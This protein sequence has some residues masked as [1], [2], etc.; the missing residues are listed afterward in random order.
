MV[1]A[2]EVNQSKLTSAGQ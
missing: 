2:M 1:F